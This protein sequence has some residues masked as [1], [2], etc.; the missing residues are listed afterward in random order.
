MEPFAGKK[1]L[2]VKSVGVTPVN[3]EE[4]QDRLNFS[5]VDYTVAWWG[6]C[7][8]DQACV[9]LCAC[10]FESYLFDPLAHILCSP[11]P[12]SVPLHGQY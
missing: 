7:Q 4:R 10:K 9:C 8:I 6:R 5:R 1:P 11:G 2:S 3:G 12:D